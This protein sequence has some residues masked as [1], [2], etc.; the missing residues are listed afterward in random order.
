MHFF[1]I[2]LTDPVLVF[3]VVLLV[4]LISPILFSKIKIPGIVGLIL[5]GVLLGPM[6]RGKKDSRSGWIP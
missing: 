6:Q 1:K 3:S 4:I 2:P 5:S